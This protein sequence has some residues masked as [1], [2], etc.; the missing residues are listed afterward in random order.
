MGS[1]KVW[2]GTE[3][4]LWEQGEGQTPLKTKKGTVDMQLFKCAN[5]DD[6][7]S[8][9]SFSVAADTFLSLTITGRACQAASNSRAGCY[10]C[11]GRRGQAGWPWRYSEL[12]FISMSPSCLHKQKG[13][14]L[15]DADFLWV[16][17]FVFFFKLRCLSLCCRMN[18]LINKSLHQPV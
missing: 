8:S 3:H 18:V 14:F 2:F 15:I 12:W 16:C 10:R 6:S 1:R 5:G 7:G 13:E 4:S 17:F 11:H 9:C